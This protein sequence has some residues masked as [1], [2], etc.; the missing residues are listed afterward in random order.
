MGHLKQIVDYLR[1]TG[2]HL[3][4]GEVWGKVTLNL[5]V[6]HPSISA[7]SQG[8]SEITGSGWAWVK[9]GA[10]RSFPYLGKTAS[11][12]HAVGLGT[13][14]TACQGLPAARERLGPAVCGVRAGLG[15]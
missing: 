9:S 11:A 4:E 8:W 14:D 12:R 13:L 5:T 3:Q 1:A 10:A 6:T 2:H 7:R 15:G